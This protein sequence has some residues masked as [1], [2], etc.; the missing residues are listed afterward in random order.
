MADR[1]TPP[2]ARRW[3]ACYS[4]ERRRFRV[5]PAVSQF[6]IARGCLLCA[7]ESCASATSRTRPLVPSLATL[8]R[9]Q[10]S[11]GVPLRKPRHEVAAN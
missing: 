4:R 8:A 3:G 7:L 5:V 6:F 9:G 11:L 10:M 2:L 1:Y